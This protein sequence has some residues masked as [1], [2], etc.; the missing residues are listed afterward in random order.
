MAVSLVPVLAKLAIPLGV[1]LLF[2]AARKGK[3]ET[4]T[5]AAALTLRA[6]EAMQKAN[7]SMLEAVADDFRDD[8]ADP[9]TAGLL[10]FQKAR[11]VSR[12]TRGFTTV[13]T[14]DDDKVL[15]IDNREIVV[16]L[17]QLEGRAKALDAWVDAYSK[18]GAKNIASILRTKAKA[19]RGE[20]DPK[21][22]TAAEKKAAADKKRADEKAKSKGEGAAKPDLTDV[23]K[24]V[25]EAL[26][27][28][29][30]LTM[31]KVAADLRS[32]GFTEQADSLDAAADEL[33]A[34][35]K[36]DKAADDARKAKEAKDKGKPAPLP[37]PEPEPP[38]THRKVEVTSKL[39]S[40]SAIT[41]SLLG[42]ADRMRELVAINI[43]FDADGRARQKVTAALIAQKGINPN[44]MGGL[45]PGLQPG[46]S[47]WVPDGWTLKP[48]DTKP[49]K[50]VN[51]KP[52]TH[53]KPGTG[54]ALTTQLITMLE[55][56]S[57]GQEDTFMV[58]KWQK[59]NNRSADG[60][61]GPG[62]AIFMAEV[63]GVVPPSP[64]YWPKN[65]TQKAL[66]LWHQEMNRFAIQRP[67]DTEAYQFADEAGKQPGFEGVSSGTRI[68]SRRFGDGL[69]RL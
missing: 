17:I 4:A 18:I 27:S 56:K 40:E 12:G 30:V 59:A 55:G 69:G 49:A 65:N 21:A 58:K 35:L 36:A 23:V 11:M 10:D 6:V 28:G 37:E 63:L 34:E 19:L 67:S 45:Y 33:E 51:P 3:S 48:E 62:D 22:D 13:P 57:P 42:K 2:V 16:R 39:N 47:L 31:R 66:S 20:T 9:T 26:A 64:L 54:D 38:V 1:G 41:K 61:Y 53:T 60:K 8:D 68:V 44:R 5:K 46:Q 25:T 29:S 14:Y 24:Q 7:G 32:H 15:A 43:P 52:A 50:P